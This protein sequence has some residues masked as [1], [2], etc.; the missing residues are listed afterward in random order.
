MGIKLKEA[1]STTLVP[2]AGTYSPRG[3]LVQKSLPSFS[4]GV[5]LQSSLEAR[6]GVPGPGQ[7]RQ[8][9]EKLR[10]SSPKFG[11][12]SS[13][14]PALGGS[15]KFNTPGPGSYAL[16]SK[17]ADVPEYAMPGRPSQSKYV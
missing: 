17:I 5:K 16:P 7:Y 4:M 12:G 10:H 1:Q 14:R 11:F 13:T 15:G 9:S 3:K 8:D 2:G 6:K